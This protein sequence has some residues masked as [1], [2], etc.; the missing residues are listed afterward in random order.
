MCWS[1]WSFQGARFYSPHQFGIHNLG[2][3][4]E[5]SA[6]ARL[7]SA[8]PGPSETIDFQSE[9]LR[10]AAVLHLHL[11]PIAEVVSKLQ[12][13]NMDAKMESKMIHITHAIQRQCMCPVPAI[14]SNP[15][16]KRPV[17][18]QQQDN[19]LPQMAPLA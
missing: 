19:S 16:R 14:I 8:S 10:L 2:G 7:S 17:E 9:R 13:V 5:V 15:N 12:P 3:F 4:I 18:I 1:N 11:P 6:A